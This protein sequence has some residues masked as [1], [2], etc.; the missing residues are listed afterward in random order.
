MMLE[1]SLQRKSLSS[2]LANLCRIMIKRLS[3]FALTVLSNAKEVVLFSVFHQTVVPGFQ[4]GLH[5]RGIVLGPVLVGCPHQLQLSLFGKFG[6]NED[7]VAP[8]AGQF[9]DLAG[10]KP[11]VASE[12]GAAV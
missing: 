3:V 9:L 2:V 12:P 11:P 5:K 7:H 4:K 10:T 8:L 6:V 1:I